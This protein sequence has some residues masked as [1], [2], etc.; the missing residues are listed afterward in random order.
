MIVNFSGASVINHIRPIIPHC[1]FPHNHSHNPQVHN[2]RVVFYL[3]GPAP[4][5]RRRAIRFTSLR[6]VLAPIPAAYKS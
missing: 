4:S 6:S 3:G 1:F 2:D 5:G